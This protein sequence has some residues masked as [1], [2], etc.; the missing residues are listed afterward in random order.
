MS[1]YSAANV[2][3]LRIYSSEAT[4]FSLFFVP[5]VLFVTSWKMPPGSVALMAAY[6]ERARFRA[7]VQAKAAPARSAKV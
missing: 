1:R 3:P 5:T 6:F 7:I 4:C 2:T